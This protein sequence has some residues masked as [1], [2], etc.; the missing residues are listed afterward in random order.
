[1]A[2]ALINPFIQKERLQQLRE[3]FD[4]F[5]SLDWETLTKR[6]SPKSWSVIEVFEH[7][8]ISHKAYE[9]KMDKCMT[10]L[11]EA[12][13][14]NS[15]IS[16]RMMPSF[17]INRFPPKEGKVKFK[18][19]TFKKF[20]PM[21]DQNAITEKLVSNTFIN[22]EKSIVHLENAVKHYPAKD[23]KSISF[24]SAIGALVRFN[25]AEAAEFVLCHNER[26]I[27]QAKNTFD[28]ILK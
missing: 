11:T 5:K 7:M 3:D 15:E 27:L 6:P 16:A 24:N 19:K 1:M 4:Y 18:M 9:S 22:F 26:H 25:I 28:K 10:Q 12:K 17:L 2:R 13:T 21:F 8:V 23:I 14:E 20:V